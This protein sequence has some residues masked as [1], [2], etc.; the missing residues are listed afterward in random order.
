MMHL[1]IR[2]FSRKKFKY[3]KRSKGCTTTDN[4]LE[5]MFNLLRKKTYI[6]IETANLIVL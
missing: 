2:R 5:L 3:L 1:C 4:N 6:Y